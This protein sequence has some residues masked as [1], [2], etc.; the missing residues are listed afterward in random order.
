MKLNKIIITSLITCTGTG[1]AITGCTEGQNYGEATVNVCNVDTVI[2]L[3]GN[4]QTSPNCHIKLKFAYLN[5]Y[6]EKDSTSEKV[7]RT[8]KQV[9]FGD[10]YA[11]LAPHAFIDTIT[12]SLANDYRRDVLESYKT[13]LANGVAPEDMPQWYN[14]DFQI[15]SEL[16]KGRDSIWNY[17]VVTSQYT[18]GAHPNTWSKWVN[19][20]ALS[21]KPVTEN[22]AFG[23]ADKE[24]IRQLLLGKIIEAV[25]ERLETDTI[26]TIDGL[27]AN[28]VLLDEEVFIPENFL[29]TNDGIEFLY[30]PYEIAPYS[31]GSFELKLSDEK[32]SSYLNVK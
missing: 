14:Y 10:L 6:S 18:G 12:T 24:G 1:I 19:I 11:Q 3:T 9:F 29:L 7:N 8:L 22:D 4:D 25:N 20:D 21:G 31:M 32:I 28:G 17:K 13:D 5:P 16:E 27:H 2:Y 23:H 30:N 15:T 26:S